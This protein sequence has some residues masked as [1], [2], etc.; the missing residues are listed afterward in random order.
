M[1]TTMIGG[2]KVFKTYITA[3]KSGAVLVALDKDGMFSLSY[4]GLSEGDA[5]A[6]AQKF[7]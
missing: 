4:G 7:D 1:I 5:V 3:K 2:L 6:L